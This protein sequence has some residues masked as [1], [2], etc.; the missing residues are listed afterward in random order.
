MNHRSAQRPARQPAG[1]VLGEALPGTASPWPVVALAAA[2]FT[3]LAAEMFPVATLPQLAAGLGVEPGRAGL[4]LGGYAVVSGVT[5]VP[6]VALTRGVDRRVLLTGSMVLLSVSQLIFGLSQG[7]ASAMISRG[8]AALAHG[9]IW[10]LAPVV[11][12]ELA[13]ASRRAAARSRTFLGSSL[14]L[15]ASGPLLALVAQHWG[16]RAASDGIAVL[17][18]LVALLLWKVLPSSPARAHRLQPASDSV[19]PGS[20]G[21]TARR[22]AALRKPVRGEGLAGVAVVCMVTIVLVVAHYVSYTYLAVLLVSKGIGGSGFSLALLC[23]GVAGLLGVL[24][25]GRFLDA[26][27]FATAI[28]MSLVLT[29]SL[30]LGMLVSQPIGVGVA[31]FGWGMAFSAAPAILQDAVVRRAGPQADVASAVY[32]VAFQIGISSGSG[33]G[34]LLLTGPTDG[35]D[36]MP[37][38][39]VSTGGA[40][41]T[42][43]LVLIGRRV[44]AK[45]PAGS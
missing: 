33:L 30:T 4:L 14:S 38:W 28:A 7:F 29:I 5:A 24:L 40:A 45:W 13:A 19:Q 27:P 18:A 16:W 12:G 21:E 31:L 36:G 41:L 1:Q 11:A 43:A 26:R 8:V 34:A 39:Q 37:L 17:A 44:F 23:Y 15:V 10:A 42:L 9:V 6:V 35:A 25:C 2:L 3:Y 20:P 32:V 22:E